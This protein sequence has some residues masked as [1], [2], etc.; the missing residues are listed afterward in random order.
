MTVRGKNACQLGANSCRGTGNQ[1]YTLGHDPMLLNQF[2]DILIA[3][4]PERA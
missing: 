3:S 4:A 1:R 2:G